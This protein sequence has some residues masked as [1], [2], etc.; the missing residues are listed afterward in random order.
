MSNSEEMIQIL[1][2]CLNNSMV[3]QN[4]V[5]H[6]LYV[7]D[8]AFSIGHLAGLVS[9][10]RKLLMIRGLRVNFFFKCPI[11]ELSSSSS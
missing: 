2:A 1:K 6:V 11:K 10:I 5:I 7:D 3:F 8:S 4:L 9:E